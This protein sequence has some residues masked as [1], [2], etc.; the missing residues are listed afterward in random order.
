MAIDW[1]L[2][3]LLLQLHIG[4]RIHVDDFRLVGRVLIHKCLEKT[5]EGN[6]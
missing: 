2:E 3:I 4:A 6:Q 5:E 1:C